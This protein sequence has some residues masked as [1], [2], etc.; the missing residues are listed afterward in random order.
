MIQISR[1]PIRKMHLGNE[2]SRY[3]TEPSRGPNIISI[4]DVKSNS[5]KVSWEKLTNDDSN[6][7]IIKYEV[8]YK[9]SEDTEDIDCNLKKNVSIVNTLEVTLDGLSVA[10]SYNVAVKA[11]TQVDFGD[12]G[13]VVTK[14]T[15][16]AS[17]LL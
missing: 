11:S 7:V 6:G 1:Q 17:K 4:T 2:Y 12:L 13:N 10:T 16:E 8:C 14:K 5:M 9:A 3:F 15:L